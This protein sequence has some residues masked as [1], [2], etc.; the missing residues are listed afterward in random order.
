MWLSRCAARWIHPRDG[1]DRRRTRDP[2]RDRSVGARPDRDPRDQA[3][4]G[5]RSGRSRPTVGLRGSQARGYVAKNEWRYSRSHW[6]AWPRGHRPLGPRRPR[7]WPLP[8]RIRSRRSIST[9][10]GGGRHSSPTVC[11]PK[12]ACRRSSPTVRRPSPRLRLRARPARHPSPR[13]PLRLAEIAE[14]ARIVVRGTGGS[15]EPTTAPGSWRAYS[16]SLEATA[17]RAG[18]A[19]GVAAWARWSG[20]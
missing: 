19:T 9:V 8:P 1:K 5:P 17:S 6:P 16:Y 20:P 11:R 15:S 3:M 12:V 13:L 14:I 4:I 10:H 2:E 18:S 7:S